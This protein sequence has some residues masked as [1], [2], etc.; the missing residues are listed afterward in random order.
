[1]DV[2]HQ[3]RKLPAIPQTL[4][5][6]RF[7]DLLTMILVL[8]LILMLLRC[9]RV[10]F[11][12]CA[13]PRYH[14]GGIRLCTCVRSAARERGKWLIAPIRSGLGSTFQS[15]PIFPFFFPRFGPLGIKTRIR[16]ISSEAIYWI[17]TR[18]NTDSYRAWGKEGRTGQDRTRRFRV[19]S[20]DSR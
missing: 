2:L 11:G 12:A 17:S 5:Q 20:E 13:L 4:K 3:I 14:G 19:G 18:A 9:S 7:L 6:P 8:M 1:M 10:K 15:L 16:L